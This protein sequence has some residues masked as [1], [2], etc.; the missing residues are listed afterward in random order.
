M[1]YAHPTIDELKARRAEALTYALAMYRREH[2]CHPLDTIH[3]AE[4]SRA[5]QYW[6]A[7]AYHAHGE[8]MALADPVSAR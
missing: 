3:R 5:R 7:Q 1:S 2:A 6:I 4:W 8:I